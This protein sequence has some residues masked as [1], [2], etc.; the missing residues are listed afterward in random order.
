[1]KLQ[2]LAELIQQSYR[3]RQSDNTFNQSRG[4]AARDKFDKS[5]N[6]GHAGR[7]YDGPDPHVINKT[8]YNP[9]RDTNDGYMVYMKN[10]IDDKVADTNPYAPRVYDMNVIEDRDGKSKYKIKLEKLHRCSAVGDDVIVALLNRLYGKD[11]ISCAKHDLNFAFNNSQLL[12]KAVA[13]TAEQKLRSKDK[14]LNAL[15]DRIYQLD[16]KYQLFIDIHMNNIMIRLGAT[17]QLV[18]V[19]PLS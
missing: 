7:V 6:S 18:I 11:E 3:K 15:C 4:D 14:N 12:G 9:Q 16:K 13:L 8:N 17:P 1:M 10:L 2:F 19:D 5:P